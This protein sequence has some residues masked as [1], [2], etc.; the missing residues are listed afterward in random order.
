MDSLKEILPELV[1]GK[2]CLYQFD[3]LMLNG[4]EIYDHV[5]KQMHEDYM[6]L[7]PEN[8]R[9]DHYIEIIQII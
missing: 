8:Q 1:Y 7:L 4:L 2:G 3:G 5:L 9:D 6:I